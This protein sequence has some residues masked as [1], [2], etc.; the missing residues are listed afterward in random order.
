MGWILCAES[1]GLLNSQGHVP[2]VPALIRP[3]IARAGKKTGNG[4]FLKVFSF[5]TIIDGLETRDREKKPDG[6]RLRCL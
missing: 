6:Y 4:K 1:V 5:P 2:S 3:L